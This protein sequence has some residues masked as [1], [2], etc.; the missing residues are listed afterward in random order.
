[1]FGSVKECG[2]VFLSVL[3][4]LSVVKCCSVFESVVVCF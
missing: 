1:M 4:F 2:R 3:V